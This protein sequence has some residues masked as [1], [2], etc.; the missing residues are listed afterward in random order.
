MD[1]KILIGAVM[2]VLV[3]FLFFQFYADQGDQTRDNINNTLDAS[4]Y[5]PDLSGDLLDKEFRDTIGVHSQVIYYLPVF[6]DGFFNLS[7]YDVEEMSEEEKK[8]GFIVRVPGPNLDSLTRAEREWYFALLNNTDDGVYFELYDSERGEKYDVV[9]ELFDDHPEYAKLLEGKQ[10]GQ[11]IPNSLEEKPDDGAFEVWQLFFRLFEEKL[12]YQSEIVTDGIS[13]RFGDK[14]KNE[15]N[16][17]SLYPGLKKDYSLA[18]DEKYSSDRSFFATDL[19]LDDSDHHI[20]AYIRYQPNNN[21]WI[22]SLIPVMPQYTTVKV[23]KNNA[24]RFCTDFLKKDFESA[25]RGNRYTKRWLMGGSFIDDVQ[26]YCV[27]GL[28]DTNC[29]L[30]NPPQCPSN[31]PIYEYKPST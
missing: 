7:N 4:K 30:D 11:F 28:V 26:E 3:G 14:Q 15:N 6:I 8:Q 1:T 5:M 18:L 20:N 17:N 2:F 19:I 27:S 21:E 23:F 31:L 9:N 13:F 22:I 29:N 16:E 24:Y 10:M 12:P 25:D